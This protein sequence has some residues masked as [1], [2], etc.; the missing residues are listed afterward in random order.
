MARDTRLLADA[1]LGM[2]ARW[3]RTLGY[4]TRYDAALTDNELVRLARAEDRVLLTR[5][6]ELTRR[7]NLRVLFIE[8]QEWK[9]QMQ[10]LFRDLDL[11]SPL[12][13]SRCLVCNTPLEPMLRSEAWGMVPPFVFI[14]HDQFQ[15]CSQCNQV[16]WRGT[17]WGHMKETVSA[18]C[19][20]WETAHGEKDQGQG[21]RAGVTQ[22]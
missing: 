22:L 17:H 16:F 8:S 11:P 20:G 19:A 14:Q 18:L 10:Q 5:D 3:L 4:D 15:L 7:R 12:P 2:L 1:M 9:M 13:Y 21:P 6:Q